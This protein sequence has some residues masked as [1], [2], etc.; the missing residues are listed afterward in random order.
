MRD[1]IKTLVF[2]IAVIGCL[3]TASAWG[4]S[5]ASGLEL[6]LKQ[7]DDAARTFRTTEAN[8]VSD[9]YQ[10]VIDETETQ[11]GRIFFRREGGEIQ[12]SAEFF[13]PD[14]KQVVYGHG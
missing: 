12:M 14:K 11:K 6:V 9:Q 8:L 7:M 10:K 4:Q 1:A 5:E 13:D 3:L 2:G